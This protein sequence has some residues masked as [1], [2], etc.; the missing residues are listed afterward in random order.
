MS[1]ILKLNEKQDKDVETNENID[2][3]LPIEEQAL[4]ERYLKTGE[5]PSGY[6]PP[7]A[8]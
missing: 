3:S 1:E 4:V 7:S 2:S 5:M 6:I 8:W